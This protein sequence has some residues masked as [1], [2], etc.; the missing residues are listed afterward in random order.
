MRT[1]GIVSHAVLGTRRLSTDTR[2]L[3]YDPADVAI[4]GSD[5]KVVTFTA[6]SAPVLVNAAGEKVFPK[7]T[8]PWGM[9]W[10]SQSAIALVRWGV[11][12]V[13]RASVE[14]YGRP[15]L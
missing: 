5:G 6:E 8:I 11:H 7:T 9:G 10:R 15:V 4:T 13:N 14:V 1:S 2:P 12:A 3:T